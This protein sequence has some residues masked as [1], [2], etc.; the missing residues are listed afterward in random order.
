MTLIAQFGPVIVLIGTFFE[1]EVFAII[2]GFLAYRGA[3][4][5]EM[6]IALAFTGSFFGDLSV[7][8]FARFFSNHRWVM[9][10]R[11]KP[12]FAKALGL[13]E[14]Y[15]AYFVIVNRYVYGLR[16]P[17][18]VALGLSRLSIIRFLVLNFVGA[19]LWAGIFT[20]IGF[21]FGYSIWSVFANLQLFERGAVI[22]LAVLAVLLAGY[23]GWRQ[24]GPLMAAW[25]A[26]PR[27]G[28]HAKMRHGGL[29]GPLRQMFRTPRLRDQGSEE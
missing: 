23:F 26:R 17:G 10:W 16:M 21:V 22:V 20:T 19:G 2:G 11:E 5:L 7:F 4:P 1:G 24:W 18:L 8:L 9:V 6:M 3:Y 14:R 12:R 13:V 28:R 27:Q 25:W 15:Q 29:F